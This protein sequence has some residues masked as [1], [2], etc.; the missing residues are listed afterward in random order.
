VNIQIYCLRTV[1]C[2]TYCERAS[3]SGCGNSLSPSSSAA[4]HWH[5]LSMGCWYYVVS[6][7]W[8]PY[9]PL[10]SSFTRES[11]DNSAVEETYCHLNVAARAGSD[12]PGQ[13]SRGW[14]IL[15]L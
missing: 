6:D 1:Q 10:Y 3:F 15:I 9:A 13:C 11:I 4:S 5:S 12:P 2:I 8:H 7:R 14:P